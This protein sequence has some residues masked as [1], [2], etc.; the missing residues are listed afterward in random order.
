MDLNKEDLKEIIVAAIKESTKK[1]SIKKTLTIDETVKYTGIGR[2][3]I[4]QLAHGQNDFPS[5]RVGAKFLI[6]KDMLDVWLENIAKQKV[7][8]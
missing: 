6:N 4:T 8:L 3:K 2:E 1:Q 5:F 7:V